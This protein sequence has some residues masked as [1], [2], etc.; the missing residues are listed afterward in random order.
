MKKPN[1]DKYKM[2]RYLSKPDMTFLLKSRA[3]K[4]GVPLYRFMKSEDSHISFF[5]VNRAEKTVHK[6]LVYFFI[7]K[8]NNEYIDGSLFLINGE[9]LISFEDVLKNNLDKVNLIALNLKQTNDIFVISEKVW[10]FV[11][12]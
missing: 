1:Y 10:G 8:I 4:P 2:F 3:R 12:C 5:S 6:T 9:Y 7:V 11:T